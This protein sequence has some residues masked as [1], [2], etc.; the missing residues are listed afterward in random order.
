MPYVRESLF[1]REHW[2][3]LA[4]L[5]RGA[6]HWV[7][8]VAETRAHGTTRQSPLPVFENV[9]RAHLR[10]LVRDRFDPPTWRTDARARPDHTVVF[11]RA[12]HT[13]P[14]TYV[15]RRALL[16]IRGDSKI[17]RICHRG[18]LI[19]THERQPPG[20]KSIDHSDYPEHKRGC[21]MRD[22]ERAIEE[23]ERRGPFVGEYAARLLE[24]DFPWSQLR[25]AQ[26]LFR[27]G[28]STAT[29]V[30]TRGVVERPPST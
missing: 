13:V 12:L 24:G 14:T 3:D 4:H 16:D 30:S 1:K 6:I 29:G 27:L 26:A 8:N 18:E 10:P 19:K 9:E 15:Q 5:Q 22:P 2:L 25:Q 23:A 20:G 17:V 11:H 21:T 7:V 28:P